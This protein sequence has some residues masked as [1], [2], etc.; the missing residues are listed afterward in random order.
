[1]SINNFKSNLKGFSK[2]SLTELNATASY[3]KRIDKKYLLTSDQLKELLQE[4]K[5]DFKILEIDWKRSFEYD[6]VYMDTQDYLFYNQHQNKDKIRTKVRTRLYKDIDKAFFEYKLKKNWI[7]QKF[8]Y[9]FPSKE[10]WEM[11]KWKIRFFQW[12]WQSNN[13]WEY[14]PTIFPSIWT[15]Y[16]RIALV[17]KDGSERLTI[18]YNIKT[19]N[20]RSYKSEEISLTNLIIIESK[21]LNQIS[22]SSDILHKFGHSPAKSCSKYSLW[23]IYSWLTK[24]FDTFKETIAKIKEIRLDTLKSRDRQILLKKISPKINNK[25]LNKKNKLYY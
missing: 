1:M 9:D 19:T 10:H 18:D 21:S 4:L 14:W 22:K 3:L 7:T 24:R 20:L 16:K 2:I 5:K 11:T 15:S 23:V 17:N 25:I 6:N 13:N 12:I 8:R